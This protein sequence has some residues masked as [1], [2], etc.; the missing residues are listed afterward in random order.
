MAQEVGRGWWLRQ[1]W[2]LP[3]A[4]LTPLLLLLDV[5]EQYLPPAFRRVPLYPVVLLR[6]VLLAMGVDGRVVPEM[7]PPVVHVQVRPLFVD[8]VPLSLA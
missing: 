5:V 4:P 8:P 1:V 6:P 3:V 2:L 7:L